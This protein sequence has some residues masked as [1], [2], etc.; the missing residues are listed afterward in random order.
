MATD[1]TMASG[2]VRKKQNLEEIRE[3]LPN[4]TAIGRYSRFFYISKKTVYFCGLSD[5]NIL[6]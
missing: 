6:N 4:S 3:I 5:L 1:F 2:A